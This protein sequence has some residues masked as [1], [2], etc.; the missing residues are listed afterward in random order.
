MTC[1]IKRKTYGGDTKLFQ[2]GAVLPVVEEIENYKL[3][4]PNRA[5]YKK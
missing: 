2:H 1:G 5:T 4:V 3:S